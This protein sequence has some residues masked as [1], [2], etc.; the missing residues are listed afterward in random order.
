M[1]RMGIVLRRPVYQVA[2][3]GVI[4][5]RRCVSIDLMLDHIVTTFVHLAAVGLH[6]IRT[7]Q[8][9]KATHSET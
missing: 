4:R 5:R 2:A 7:W 8:V 3:S 9:A 1:E 6:S